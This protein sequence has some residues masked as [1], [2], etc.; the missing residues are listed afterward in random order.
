MWRITWFHSWNESWRRTEWTV[1]PEIRCPT[2]QRVLSFSALAWIHCRQAIHWSGGIRA[3]RV[4]NHRINLLVVK[5]HLVIFD[6]TNPVNLSVARA[7]RPTSAE[8]WPVSVEQSD[9]RSA[10]E[11]NLVFWV[12]NDLF[13]ISSP[14]TSVAN[15]WPYSNQTRNERCHSKSRS[16]LHNGSQQFVFS[17]TLH[18]GRWTGRTR[19]SLW[20]SVNRKRKKS[21]WEL[22]PQLWLSDLAGA[23]SPP[24]TS[25]NSYGKEYRMSKVKPLC[26][27]STRNQQFSAGNEI[28]ISWQELASSVKCAEV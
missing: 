28:N 27:R 25:T 22:M 10:T 12:F 2:R 3:V 23:P 19:P 24:S 20:P 21:I 17:H 1:H 16:L 26:P 8:H 14:V 5:K 9:M 7:I 6:L 11:A 18:W 4:G 15:L 13:R